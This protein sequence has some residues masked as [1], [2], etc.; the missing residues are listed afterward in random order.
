MFERPPP[1]ED[2]CDAPEVPTEVGLCA[3]EEMEGITVVV[4]TIGRP[5]EGVTVIT[6]TLL[7]ATGSLLP[8]DVEVVLVGLFDDEGDRLKAELMGGEAVFAGPLDDGGGKVEL[9]TGTIMLELY[10]G[11]NDDESVE[12]FELKLDSVEPGVPVVE[13]KGIGNGIDGYWA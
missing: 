2:G 13:F 10:P 5:T 6:T 7:L 3:G 4:T 9:I 1:L 12:E 8:V 11:V